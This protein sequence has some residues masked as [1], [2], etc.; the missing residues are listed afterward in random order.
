[1]PALRL[2]ACASVA[3]VAA[4]A[5]APGQATPALAT[6][7]PT[8]AK[9]VSRL[10][11]EHCAG[12]HHAG[13][14]GPFSLLSYR[15]T[16]GW[17]EMIKE[18]VT[19]R[20][21][22]PWHADPAVGKFKNDRRLTDEE[23]ATI[24]NWIDSGH[25]LGNEA[26]MPA[27]L[28]FSQEWAIESPDAIFE[29]P[30]EVT[31][32]PSGVVPYMEFEV[33]TNFTEDMWLQSIEARAGNPKVVHHIIVFVRSP[34]LGNGDKEEFQRLGRGFLVGFAPGVMPTVFQEGYAVKVPKGSTFV[35]QMH[36]T[37]TGKTEVDKSKL[38]VVFAK[39]PPQHEMITATTI[40][41]DF[42]IPAGADNH[43]VQ[44]DSVL[45]SDG[46]LFAMTPHMH[47]RGKAF[48]YI[49]HYPDGKSETLLRV[50]NY[51]FNWQTTYVLEKPAVLPKGTRIQTIAHFDNSD[52]NKANPDPTRPVRWGEQTWEEM[53]I[54]WMDIIWI[55]PGETLAAA[56]GAGFGSSAR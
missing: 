36:Y 14:I 54:G 21:M 53:M 12:C 46:V 33:P 1:M 40:N 17:G 5:Q 10:M 30:K 56:S 47:Y 44:A 19:N 27:P 15:Q 43:E 25:P 35:F 45:P 28:K 3:C 38:G 39:S 16:K 37:P 50:P 13:G 18:V 34:D 2:F 4:F 29:I 9:E 41:F 52:K 26:D 11:Q 31:I 20:T 6:G 24:V 32:N 55:K 42:Q 8:Y 51:D 22:P 49:A 48:E 7:N 23:I